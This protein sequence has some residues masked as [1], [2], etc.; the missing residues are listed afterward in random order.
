V[1]GSSRGSTKE[2]GKEFGE[3][4]EVTWK[5]DKRL[6]KGRNYKTLIQYISNF[7]A[8]KQ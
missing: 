5:S 2:C 6:R 7:E 4:G 1:T 3:G 8:L